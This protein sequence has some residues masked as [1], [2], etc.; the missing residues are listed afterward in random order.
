MKHEKL[1]KALAV[2]SAVLFSILVM[3]GVVFSVL[4]EKNKIVASAEEVSTYAADSDSALF[5]VR[6][7]IGID[8]HSVFKS[9]VNTSS[10]SYAITVFSGYMSYYSSG[11]VVLRVGN[12]TLRDIVDF[13]TP[14]AYI[15]TD[16]SS[17]LA[18]SLGTYTVQ[19][20]TSL[21]QSI[22]SVG[23]GNQGV[24][25]IY[26]PANSA[27]SLFSEVEVQYNEGY[28]AGYDDGYK[29]GYGKGLNKGQSDSLTNPVDYLLTPVH[30][31]L[32]L[33][34]FGIIAIS[35]MLNIVLFV[36]IALIFIKMFSGG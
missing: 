13:D 10:G 20:F 6:S 23:Y 19:R 11:G 1:K 36:G 7:P 31:F 35:D 22:A 4:S 8:N 21:T 12:L 17:W 30:D 2:V 26:A 14:L 18:F 15:S 16:P 29:E 32:N 25:I 28:N 9:L 24:V 27:D 33:R 3:V 5:V 34:L